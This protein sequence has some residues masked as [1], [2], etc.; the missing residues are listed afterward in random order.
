[1]GSTAQDLSGY[2]VSYLSLSLTGGPIDGVN[3]AGLTGQQ[4][5]LADLCICVT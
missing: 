4:A 1:M 5:F 3:F 2:S